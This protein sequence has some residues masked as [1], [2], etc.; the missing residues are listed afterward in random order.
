ML[1]VFLSVT[2]WFSFCCL[3]QWFLKPVSTFWDFKNLS[4]FQIFLFL[5]TQ[6]QFSHVCLFSWWEVTCISLAFAQEQALVLGR[7]GIRNSPINRFNNFT[8]NCRF[9]TQNYFSD[10]RKFLFLAQPEKLTSRKN[11]SLNSAL[12]FFRPVYRP[13]RPI[14]N[15]PVNC[16]RICEEISSLLLLL[17]I[18]ILVGSRK[19]KKKV[20]IT[21]IQFKR[22]YNNN[23]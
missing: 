12:P 19:R 4:T 13:S 23:K 17:S 9:I 5:S 14:P 10:K 16:P 2:N 3:K 18:N 1:V 22:D 21:I 6:Q 8:F 20:I 15:D 7:P 11:K